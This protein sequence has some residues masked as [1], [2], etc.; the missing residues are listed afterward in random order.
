[1]KC[2]ASNDPLL[3]VGSNQTVTTTDTPVPLPGTLGL[4]GAACAMLMASRGLGSRRLQPMR[5]G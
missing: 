1:M 3:P 4:F 5:A 2:Y